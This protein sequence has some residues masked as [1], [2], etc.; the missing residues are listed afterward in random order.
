[1]AVNLLEV[2][3]TPNKEELLKRAKEVGLLAEKYALKADQDSKLPDEVI[4]KI[5]EAGFH[6]LMR[7]KAYGGQYLD[8]FT[9]GEIIR[10]IANHSVAAAWLSYF[11]VIHE[12]CCILA[13]R[14]PR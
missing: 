2:K 12:T 5:K 6:K 9:F 14:K 10:T 4:E 3:K 13:K 8:Y 1:M 11:F 7:P